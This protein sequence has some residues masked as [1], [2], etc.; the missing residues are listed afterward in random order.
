MRKAAVAPT[1]VS[2]VDSREEAGDETSWPRPPTPV[3]NGQPNKSG[4]SDVLGER[5]WTVTPLP[6]F[7]VVL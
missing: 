5:R 7:F 3:C 2:A 6:F 4:Q 1:P